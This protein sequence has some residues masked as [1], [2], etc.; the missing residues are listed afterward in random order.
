MSEKNIKKNI[1][2]LRTS[3]KQNFLDAYIVPHND[4]SLSEYVPNNKERLKWISGFSGSAGTLLLTKNKLLLFTDGRYLLQAEEQT[5]DFHCK[6]IDTSKLSLLEYLRIN[7]SQFRVLGIESKLVSLFEYSSFQNLLLNKKNKIKIINKNLID[8]LWKR[9]LNIQDLKKVFFLPKKYVGV[10]R[11]KKIL[12]VSSYLKNQRSDY[13]FTQDS[14]SVAWLYNLRGAD[15]PHTPLTT[16][17]ALIGINNQKIFFDADKIPANLKNKFGSTTELYSMRELSKVLK[18]TCNSSSKIIIDQ[19]KISLFNYTL[20]KAITKNILIKNDILLSYR[21]I[22][23]NTEV[24][25]SK[26]AHILDGIAMCKFLYWFKNY[27]GS[28]S[29][30]DVVNKV[31]NLR[32][33][34]K[35]FICT[36][37]PTIAGA[38][39]NGAIIHYQPSIDTNK[40]IN[41]KDI[42]LLDSGGQYLFGTTDVTRTITRNKKISKKIIHAYT[43]V[44]KSHISVN[45]CKFPP[46]APGSFLDAIARSKLWDIGEDFAHSTGHGVGF[47]LNVH[48]GPF[49][50]S[51]KNPSP[52]YK[53]MIFSNEPGIYK[54]KEYGIRIE[55]L[56]FTKSV[57][58]NDKEFLSLETLT[59]VPYESNLIDVKLLSDKEKKWLN[60]YHNCVIK[61]IIPY[62]NY[63]ESEWLKRQCKKV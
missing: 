46:G 4:E 31:N 30:L 61:N 25:C 44:L 58:F 55:N 14:E 48:E 35:G 49:S 1:V 3:M 27:S 52:I 9:A 17:S 53:N 39:S 54:E 21:S 18:K 34:N 63:P 40:K 19:N 41:K 8:A 10:T 29:E 22:K 51:L 20:L 62:L 47:C 7:Q 45:L 12:R 38:G 6:I 23:N 5:R 57:N 32:S 15:L 37:F 16:C 11:S 59:L 60:N 26:Y 24:N 33:Q 28:L 50:I 56:V 13:I 42:L 2:L 36:S 43:S